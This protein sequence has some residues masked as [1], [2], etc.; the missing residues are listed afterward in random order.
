M[1]SPIIEEEEYICLVYD[2]TYIYLKV[3]G[4]KRAHLFRASGQVL[5]KGVGGASDDHRGHHGPNGV[6]TASRAGVRV[7]FSYPLYP[8]D[9]FRPIFLWTIWY[10]TKTLYAFEAHIQASAG[11]PQL[12]LFRRTLAMGITA[13]VASKPTHR[14]A[15]ARLTG[16][17]LATYLYEL[18]SPGITV[19]LYEL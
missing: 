18:E 11:G 13:T 2:L 10:N 15:S 17:A 9:F 19:Y 16:V 14:L 3:C 12:G 5:E 7:I 6:V 4:P 8:Y 1:A